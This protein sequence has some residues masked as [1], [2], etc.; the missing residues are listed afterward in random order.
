VGTA[1][2]SP[3]GSESAAQDTLQQAF[4]RAY[5]KLRSVGEILNT[6]EGSVKMSFF[7]ATRK[8]RFQLNKYTKRNGSLMKECCD[9]GANQGQKVKRRVLATTVAAAGDAPMP[10]LRPVTQDQILIIAAYGALQKT[11]QELSPRRDRTSISPQMARLIW[12]CFA[13][14]GVRR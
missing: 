9:E 5:L 11:I 1:G 10:E 14:D 12:R 3:S 8:L 6:S 4:L 7:W 2:A 13:R